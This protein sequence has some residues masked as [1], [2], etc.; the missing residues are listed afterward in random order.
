MDDDKTPATTAVPDQPARP[1]RPAKA[2][3]VTKGGLSRRTVII[4]AGAAAG[5]LA[6]S[7]VLGLHTIGPDPLALVQ[8]GLAAPT[9]NTK[10]WV[11]PLDQPEAQVAQLLRRTT[12]GMTRAQHDA[13]LKDGFKTTVDKL[14]EHAGRAAQGSRRR[15]CRD[16]GQADQHRSAADMVARSHAHDADAIRGSA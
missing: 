6:V 15:G 7:R 12:F 14:V 1:P 4:G 2:A 3:T 16:P 8:S 11:S 13:A 5:G 9:V 10:D